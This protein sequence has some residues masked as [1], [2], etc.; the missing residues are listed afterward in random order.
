M[1]VFTFKLYEMFMNCR[2]LIC[3]LL[4]VI[5]CVPYTMTSNYNTKIFR[6]YI[7]SMAILA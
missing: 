1:T 3:S 2:S 6:L 5:D 7:A 4:N